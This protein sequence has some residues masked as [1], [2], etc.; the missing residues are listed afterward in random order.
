MT[1]TTTV[2]IRPAENKTELYCRYGDQTNP[3]GV[4]IELD[5]ES[6]VLRAMYNPEI[7]NAVPCDV[8]HG[9][10]LRYTIPCYTASA[11]NDLLA[12]LVPLA[13]RVLDGY[14]SEWD[15]SNNVGKL[16]ADAQAA[17]EQISA[18]CEPEPYAEGN[19]VNVCDADDWLA[20]IGDDDDQRREY[21]ITATTT[22]PELDDIA[23]RIA[24]ESDCDIIEGLGAYLSR[25]RNGAE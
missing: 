12:S 15:G 20:G 22:D 2:T 18:I 3:Q 4:L 25:L 9:R 17:S 8:W 1:M 13:Q 21:K 6:G 24:R 23:E 10:S 11:A 5:C 7:G 19:T 16:A 14:T